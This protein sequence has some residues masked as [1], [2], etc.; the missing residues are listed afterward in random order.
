MRL[1]PPKGG[2]CEAVPFF[3]WDGLSFFQAAKSVRPVESETTMS[4][5]NGN[6]ERRSDEVRLP[7]SR[8]IYVEGSAGARVP[9]REVSLSPTRQPNGS[10]EANEPVRV[11]DTSGPW[12]DPEMK[13]DVRDGLPALRREWIVARGDVE[14]YEGREVVPQDDGYLT[15]GAAEYAKNRD[16][17][18]LEPF[19]GLRR[20]P[21]RARAGAC[22]TQMHY[23]KRGIITPEMEF[24]ALRE[25]MG[26]EAAL[27]AAR[28]KSRDD[29]SSLA[30]RASRPELRRGSPFIR[31]ARV[32]AP[33]GCARA[34]DH[35][36]ERQ[37][38]RKPS[39]WQSVATF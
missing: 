3:K 24:V 37:S 4:N 6:G 19:P 35:P 13:C 10:V 32:R 2:A 27:D 17:G 38:S 36:R 33:R 14:E 1:V 11:Y 31:H 9:F 25:N 23:A 29:R 16:K 22:V 8:R 26:R 30:S 15:E 5:E 20:S 34:R 39:R 18:K 12:G 21:L 7:N 28:E